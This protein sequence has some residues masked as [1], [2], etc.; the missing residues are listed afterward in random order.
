MITY[1]LDQAKTMTTVFIRKTN[2]RSVKGRSNIDE[3]KDSA[4]F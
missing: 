2:K 3:A 1:S 4:F